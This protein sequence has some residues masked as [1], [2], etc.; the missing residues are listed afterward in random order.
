MRV[1]APH[2]RI[3]TTVHYSWL[4]LHCMSRHSCKMSRSPTFCRRA[5]A[6]AHAALYE[7]PVRQAPIC[8]F[9]PCWYTAAPQPKGST[10]R[11]CRRLPLSSTCSERPVKRHD[12]LAGI[13]LE[14]HRCSM[15]PRLPAPC[16]AERHAL[17]LQ[18]QPCADC[19]PSRPSRAAMTTVPSSRSNASGASRACMSHTPHRVQQLRRP[20]PSEALYF[21]TRGVAGTSSVKANAPKASA[22]QQG[23]I[24]ASRGGWQ[25]HFLDARQGGTPW[26]P[27]RHPAKQSLSWHSSWR[28]LH[29]PTPSPQP[30]T[31]PAGSLY[32]ATLLTTCTL[33]RQAP[34]MSMRPVASLPCAK[35]MLLP[36]EMKTAS[37]PFHPTPTVSPPAWPRVGA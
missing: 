21:Q 32:W 18:L 4:R 8:L 22:L 28:T 29:A 36:T 12:M 33:D 25:Q 24:K 9:H 6:G 31:R 23:R 11:G 1:C 16:A 10:W 5:Q 7:L 26:E 19:M 20:Q 27:V 2:K 15:I 14:P 17:W 30:P 13:L 34:C 3:L 35:I 37:H